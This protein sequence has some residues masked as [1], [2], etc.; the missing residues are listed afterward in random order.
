MRKDSESERKQVEKLRKEAADDDF[1]IKQEN[2]DSDESN[3]YSIQ[4]D[5]EK[6]E[7]IERDLNLISEIEQLL[8][9]SIISKIMR[10]FNFNLNSLNKFSGS[11]N[12]KEIENLKRDNIAKYIFNLFQRIVIKINSPWI[13]Y[14]VEY[15][16]IIQELLNNKLFSEDAYFNGLKAL[17]LGIIKSFFE[18]FKKNKLLLIESLFHFSGPIHK[19]QILNDYDYI[20]LNDDYNDNDN[21]QRDKN[22]LVGDRESNQE[23]KE[24]R[25]EEN[26]SEADAVYDGKILFERDNEAEANKN[27][28]KKK[29]VLDKELEELE[30]LKWTENEDMVLIDNYFEFKDNENYIHI[31]DKLFPLK[32]A[33]DIK[34]RIKTLKLKKGYEKAIRVLKKI[35]EKKKEKEDNLF[36]VIIGLSDECRNEAKK[37]KIEKTISLIKE[38]LESYKLKKSLYDNSLNLEFDCVLIPTSND[39]ID[40]FNDKKFRDFI[41]NIGFIPPENDF[42]I[43]IHEV[44]KNKNANVQVI[45]LLQDEDNSDTITENK[46]MDLVENSETVKIIQNIA[47]NNNNLNIIEAIDLDKEA[48]NGEEKENKNTPFRKNY[49]RESTRFWKVDPKSDA[50]DIAIMIEKLENFEKVINENMM[51]NEEYEENKRRNKRAKKD[52]KKRHHKD[53]KHKKNKKSKKKNKEKNK[54]KEY[55]N[56]INFQSGSESNHDNEENEYSKHEDSGLSDRAASDKQSMDEES[57]ANSFVNEKEDIEEVNSMNDE[58]KNDKLIYLEKESKMKRFKKEDFYSNKN[59]ATEKSKISNNDLFE[60]NKEDENIDNHITNLPNEDA[61]E[62]DFLN[63]NLTKNKKRLKKGV[64]KTDDLEKMLNE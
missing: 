1:I 32:T 56:E 46:P 54:Y 9:Y 36:N 4:S 48:G 47:T 29:D 41:K 58:N 19:N 3:N 51:V 5:E 45:D 59:V 20:E 40:I 50:T 55:D 27:K 28:K 38:Q 2:D 33:K 8:D 61:D 57:K 10:L 18:L 43:E 21:E 30:L 16:S 42:D 22:N 63:H 23:H 62:L 49:N 60:R 37:A 25:W 52:K 11:D 31:L 17:F 35:H 53:K 64:K 26:D 15:L 34:H 44:E 12:F 24:R 7:I 13:F 14:Q 39:E 6:Y